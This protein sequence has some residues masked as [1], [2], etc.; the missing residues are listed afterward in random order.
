MP[1]QLAYAQELQVV[2]FD[3]GR[4][5]IGQLL[6]LLITLMKRWGRAEVLPRLPDAAEARS[7]GF[8]GPR[9]AARRS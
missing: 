9:L 7:P 3:S 1:A 6:G 2:L 8:G 4:G 5:M